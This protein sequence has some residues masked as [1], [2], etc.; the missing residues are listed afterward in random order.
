M[1]YIQRTSKKITENF[2]KELLIDREIITEDEDYQSKFFNPT[3]QNLEDYRLLDNIEKGADLLEKHLKGGRK[4]Y[5]IVDPDIDGFSSSAVLYNY[6]TEYYRDKYDYEIEYHIPDGKEHGL[7]TLMK[8]LE[9]K[10]YYDLIICPDSSSNDYEAHEKLSSL[11][12]E[13]LVLD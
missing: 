6:I 3:K 11:G 7:D 12:Y 8:F 9:N 5:L 4:I 1:K 2:L 10:K 13:I